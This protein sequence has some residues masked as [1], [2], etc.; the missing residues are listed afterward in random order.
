M[1]KA[2]ELE[3]WLV[4]HPGGLRAGR[5]NPSSKRLQNVPLGGGTEGVETLIPN[6]RELSN[7][8]ASA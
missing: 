3:L 2:A 1:W 6:I 4:F 7:G 5:V 8:E